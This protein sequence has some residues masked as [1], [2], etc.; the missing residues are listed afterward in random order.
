[1]TSATDRIAAAAQTV[2]SASSR[3]SGRT[4]VTPR[5]RRMPRSRYC[6]MTI[7]TPFRPRMASTMATLMDAMYSVPIWP[8]SPFCGSLNPGISPNPITRATGRPNT[9]MA[10][11][12]SRRN[13]LVSVRASLPNPF[14]FPSSAFHAP[15][16]QRHVG[17]V[18]AASFDPQV[19][20]EDLPAR[21]LGGDG[22]GE[23][24]GAGDVD[25]L[26]AAGDRDDAGQRGQRL[27]GQRPHRPEPHPVLAPG[28]VHQS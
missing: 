27:L 23:V 24:A 10:A 7:G 28:P 26:T 8:D 4:G 21:Q 18:Q 22:A 3:F 5:R 17:A 15:A 25:L 2:R 20:Q 12:C 1:M 9:P 11:A 19:G 14:I 16:G 6:P 13:S